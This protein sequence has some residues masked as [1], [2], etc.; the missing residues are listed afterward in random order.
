[1]GGFL[2]RLP[3]LH[4]RIISIVLLVALFK[5]TP[6]LIKALQLFLMSL[7]P[8]LLVEVLLPKT[9]AELFPPLLVETQ[10]SRHLCPEHLFHQAVTDLIHMLLISIHAF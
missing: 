2:D 1:M 10:G 6:Q 7:F 5:R 9:L 3:V 4:K 8:F